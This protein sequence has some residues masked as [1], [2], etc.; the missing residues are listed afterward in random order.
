MAGRAGRAAGK[1]GGMAQRHQTP[2]K[3][4]LGRTLFLGGCPPGALMAACLLSA[5]LAL[6]PP[7]AAA[8]EPDQPRQDE[9]PPA[10]YTVDFTLAAGAERGDG[11]DALLDV[12]RDAS[13]LAGLKDNP[14]PSLPGLARRI[15]KDQDRLGVALR[16][17]G[18]YD[19]WIDIA[20]AAPPAPAPHDDDAAADT[21]VALTVTVHA[22]PRTRLA[23][24]ALG[25]PDGGLPPGGPV[26][27][28]R[29]GLTP[30]D[31]ARAPAIRDAEGRLPGLLA[32]RG[33]PDAVVA[34]RTLI[35]D[36]ATHTMDV[37]FLV[38]PGPLTRLGPTRFS[39]LR[40]LDESA[41]ARRLPWKE[42]D[43]YDPALVDKARDR[44]TDLGVFSQVRL[45]LQ[46]ADDAAPP[47]PPSPLPTNPDGS[48]TRPV[49]AEVRERDRHFVTV[50]LNWGT[51]D[52]LSTSA[53]WGDRDL[54]GGAEP[55]TVTGSVGGIGRKKFRPSDPLDYSLGGTLK[56]PDVVDGDGTLTLSA[57]AVSEHPEAYSRDA[58][59]LGATLQYPLTPKL[60]AGVGVTFEQEALAE[61]ETG[62][63]ITLTRNTN[64]TLVGLPLSLT[65]DDSNNL[66]DP[67]RGVRLAGTLTPYL[68]PLGDVSNLFIIGKAQASA[69]LPLDDDAFY[70]VAGRLAV[71]GVFGG[72]RA[73]VPADKRFYA[74]GGGSIRGYGYQQVGPL[75]AAGKPSGGL[76][77][78]ETGL[79]LRVRLSDSIGIA[80][81]LDGG[82]TYTSDFLD[83]GRGLRWGAG[84][85][86]RYYT[87]FG[88]VRLDVG[89]PLN[90]RDGDSAWQ[91]YISIGQSF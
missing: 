41:A 50:G 21:P 76:S 82:N 83:L 69:Y 84:L 1:T 89:A 65:L 40:D 23:R 59:Q 57:L 6:C 46:G 61:E 34:D 26:A 17:E 9:P 85:G 80:P 90:R 43:V 66:L 62:N 67:T 28:D 12:L 22:G 39:G 56:K 4:R 45:K 70:V 71:G 14:P 37:T 29:L 7:Q 18:F 55:L 52:G 78:V 19:G 30:G 25:T 79:E 8:Q 74:G 53:S 13:T 20:A 24:V 44:L 51:Q 15:D 60:V 64:D 5:P 63:G 35:V 77:L 54:M 58:L 42:G 49:E 72:G 88:P 81:F 47:P 3:N 2:P 11:D 75:D 48:V 16:S 10:R 36:H 68:S 33:Y 73:D 38:A 31:A 87:P 32:A 86:V 27:L 91:L